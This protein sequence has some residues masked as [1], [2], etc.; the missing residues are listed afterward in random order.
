M[1]A[2]LAAT[3][4]ALHQSLMSLATCHGGKAGPWLDQLKGSM[5]RQTK[6]M[7]FTGTNMEAETAAVEAALRNLKQVFDRVRQK[8]QPASHATVTVR[9][10]GKKA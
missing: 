4:G 6:N 3:T 10:T 1:V 5:V 7:T 9:I 2:T 8:L